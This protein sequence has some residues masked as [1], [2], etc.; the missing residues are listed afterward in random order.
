MQIVIECLLNWDMSSNTSKGPGIFGETEAFARSDEE[1]G[2]GSLHG[3]WQIW[4][5]EL[6]QRTRDALFHPDASERKR[7]REEFYQYI[8]HT[9]CTSFGSELE[10]LH[11]C[12]N[13]N[14]HSNQV[15]T[16][17]DIFKSRETQVFRDARHKHGAQI[18]G[19]RV[20]K[21]DQCGLLTSPT[22]VIDN[23]LLCQKKKIDNENA[24]NAAMVCINFQSNTDLS[25]VPKNSNVH[26]HISIRPG[27][28]QIKESIGPY[29]STK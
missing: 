14:P 28:P 26:T 3:H 25:I 6:S 7:A 29:M 17:S 5:K 2:R 19:G 13:I 10:V 9:I 15:K 23:H 20:L 8:D 12:E 16:I 11:P 22:E 1:Q 27:P 21:C 18:I 4:V 24:K